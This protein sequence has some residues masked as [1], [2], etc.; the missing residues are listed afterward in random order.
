M[1][2]TSAGPSHTVTPGSLAKRAKKEAWAQWSLRGGVETL[3][4]SIAEYLQR[5]GKVELQKNAPVKSISHSELGWKVSERNEPI[6]PE[7]LKTTESGA[8]ELIHII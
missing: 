1:V 7:V 8:N 4:E 2:C 5:S 3:P 6:Q